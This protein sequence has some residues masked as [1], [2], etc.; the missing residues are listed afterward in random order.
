MRD[1]SEEEK[2]LLESRFE[3]IRLM[4]EHSSELK[5]KVRKYL[6]GEQRGERA[7]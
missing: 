1:L 2:K 4:L 6:A 7:P 3:I 5:E